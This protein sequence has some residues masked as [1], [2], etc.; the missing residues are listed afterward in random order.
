M[1]RVEFSKK[2]RGQAF[3]RCGGNCEK[4]RAK[5]KQG[6]AEFDHIIPFYFTQDSTLENCQVL[7]VPCHRG[8]GQKTADDQRDISKAKRNWLKHTGSWPKSKNP[9]RSAGFRKTRQS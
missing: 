7:C 9:I 3:L 6:E 8:E 4:C 1:K 5:L 2:I